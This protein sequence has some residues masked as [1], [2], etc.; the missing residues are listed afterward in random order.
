MKNIQMK[1]ICELIKNSR[2]SDRELAKKIGVSQPTVTRMR[3]NLEKEGAINYTGSADLRKLGFE[4]VAISFGNLKKE[5]TSEVTARV[6]R[7]QDFLKKHPEII[8]FTTGSGF[9]SDRV[10]VSIHKNYSEYSTFISD[11]RTDWMDIIMVTGSFLISLENDNVLRPI[12][13]RYIADCLEK[14]IS[15]GTAETR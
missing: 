14:D 6:K 4:I 8:F 9:S 11:L 10:A 2:K 7:G 15:A 1:L 13:L 5:A 12:S 3:K